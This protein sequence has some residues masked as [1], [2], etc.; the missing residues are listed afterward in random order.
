VG[1]GEPP[2]VALNPGRLAGRGDDRHRG[3]RSHARN[4]V[5][6]RPGFI[7]EFSY[8]ARPRERARK[9]G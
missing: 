4:A 6:S 3:S 9:A 7:L 1:S 2:G 5:R 8:I